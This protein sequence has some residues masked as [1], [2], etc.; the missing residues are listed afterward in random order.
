M[1]TRKVPSE[2]EC[3]EL[4]W[5]NTA[6]WSKDLDDIVHSGD[7][8]KSLLMGDRIYFYGLDSRLHA[9][10]LKDMS[11]TSY[12][13]QEA[14]LPRIGLVLA[15][16]SDRLIYLGGIQE[17]SEAS[18]ESFRP[19]DRKRE[20]LGTFPAMFGHSV[21]YSPDRD[22]LVVFGGIENPL[23]EGNGMTE[24]MLYMDDILSIKSKLCNNKVTLVKLKGGSSIEVSEL[25]PKGS[26]PCRRYDHM[27][28]MGDGCLFV[29]GG[30]TTEE[31]EEEPVRLFVL[32]LRYSGNGNWTEVQ[33][34]ID[35]RGGFRFSY[36][37]NAL[38]IFGRDEMFKGDAFY[39]YSHVDKTSTKLCNGKIK[40]GSDYSKVSSKGKWPEF[41]Y[42]VEASFVHDGHL[43]YPDSCRRRFVA[44]QIKR[45]R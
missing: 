39:I 44:L 2:G 24:M 16:T 29:A 21:E 45:G 35:R 33:T 28:R 23:K 40:D 4:I 3:H 42:S 38:V 10:D 11:V 30:T 5:S 17:G 9:L 22:A 31:E 36:Y 8:R 13:E 27:S 26:P 34:Q 12:E 7:R 15:A 19:S 43:L 32:D 37:R 6:K 20:T 1:F 25:K 41:K 18:V 14:P